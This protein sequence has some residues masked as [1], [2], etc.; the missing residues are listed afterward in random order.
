MFI[1]LDRGLQLWRVVVRRVGSVTWVE[2][3][4]GRDD[5][6]FQVSRGRMLRGTSA[7]CF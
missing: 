4:D 2:D 3:R 6:L 7:T 5:E 1:C